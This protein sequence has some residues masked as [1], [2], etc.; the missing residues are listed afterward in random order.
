VLATSR[1]IIAKK[2]ELMAGT[3]RA[4][5]RAMQFSQANPQKLPAL[6]RQYF[7]ETDE[8]VFTAMVESYR[9]AAAR[10]PLI[11]PL[12]VQNVAK[13]M[14]I[15]EAAPI[16]VKYEDIVSPEPAAASAKALGL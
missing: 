8:A 2:P 5:A 12:Q 6:L 13:W 7:K 4:L 1:D 3:T 15:G 10:T 14:S 16:V 11:S 9:K